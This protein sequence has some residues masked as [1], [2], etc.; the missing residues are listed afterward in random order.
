MNI[1]VAACIVV[2]V[3]LC[4]WASGAEEMAPAEQMGYESVS[5]KEG[6]EAATFVYGAVAVEIPLLEVPPGDP[7]MERA[8]AV[9]DA[10]RVE[11][12]RREEALRDKALSGEI[13]PALF[14][15]SLIGEGIEGGP[16]K[17]L[18]FATLENLCLLGRF[19]VVAEFANPYLGPVLFRAGALQLTFESGY[20]WWLSPTVMEVPMKMVDFCT[21]EGRIKI[22]AAGLTDFYV[23]LVILDMITGQAIEITNPSFKVFDTVIGNTPFLC[24]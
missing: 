19:V 14:E 17:A 24:F 16:Q 22:F 20:M 13:P 2:V 10:A 4:G 6:A 9:A 12:A 11:M 23:R 3:L 18:C 15:G 1:R 5:S 21:S 8:R 7:L